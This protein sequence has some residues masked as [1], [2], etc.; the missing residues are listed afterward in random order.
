M[1]SA[2]PIPEFRAKIK[3]LIDNARKSP[4]RPDELISPPQ[5]SDFACFM[6]LDSLNQ[7]LKE[8]H[9]VIP[10]NTSIEQ[11]TELAEIIKQERLNS[12]EFVYATQQEQPAYRKSLTLLQGGGHIRYAQFEKHKKK[13]FTDSID[14]KVQRILEDALKN[15]KPTAEELAEQ[16]REFQRGLGARFGM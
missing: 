12:V 14:P 6:T 5:S 4:A 15:I 3:Q 2:G 16:N 10:V 1:A 7:K 13:Y 11:A 9:L 8:I